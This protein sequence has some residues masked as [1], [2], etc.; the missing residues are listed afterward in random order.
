MSL[1]HDVQEER[2][3]DMLATPWSRS[4]NTG[5]QVCR[6]WRVDT[7]G[8]SSC[9]SEHQPQP[10]DLLS[11]RCDDRSHK[12][13]CKRRRKKRPREERPRLDQ[14]MPGCMASRQNFLAGPCCIPDV[15]LTQ[16]CWMLV[17]PSSIGIAFTGRPRSNSPASA[18]A[19]TQ[20]PP[21]ACQLVF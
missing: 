3:V 12:K 17:L 7:H 10:A 15:A 18:L 13:N 4:S 11:Q 5:L 6:A 2:Q 1:L 20:G 8:A 14:M 16:H 9:F 21:W 19:Y